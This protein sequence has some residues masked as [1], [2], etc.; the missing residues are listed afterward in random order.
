VVVVVIDREYNETYPSGTK[1]KEGK[2]ISTKDTIY[3]IFK[4][5]M[6]WQVVALL[7]FW[8]WE[9]YWDGSWADVATIAALI[10][11]FGF[12]Y[13]NAHKYKALGGEPNITAIDEATMMKAVDLISQEFGIKNK[14][15]EQIALLTRLT[16]K[17]AEVIADL[18]KEA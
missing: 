9:N 5:L 7:I 17:Q 15:L 3:S 12:V 11:L 14:W 18:Q 6:A 16:E 10:T 8:F 2:E 1:E 13:A 4:Y